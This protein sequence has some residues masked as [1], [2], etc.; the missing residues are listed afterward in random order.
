[1]PDVVSFPVVGPMGVLLGLLQLIESEGLSP[2]VPLRV[3][4]VK[5]YRNHVIELHG[6]FRSV[7]KFYYFSITFNFLPTSLM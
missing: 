2:M 6:R 4:E 3:S 5:L 1:M 7:L